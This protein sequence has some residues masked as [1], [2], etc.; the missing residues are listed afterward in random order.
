M[1]IVRVGIKVHTTLKVYII[2]TI[3]SKLLSYKVVY[4]DDQTGYLQRK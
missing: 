2:S 3:L 4:Q 1:S